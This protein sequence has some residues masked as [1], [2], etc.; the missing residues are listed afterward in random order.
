MGALFGR[1]EHPDVDAIH[2]R[3]VADHVSEEAAAQA[4]RLG[5]RFP[6]YGNTAAV[7]RLVHLAYTERES[8]IGRQL[9]DDEKLAARQEA[10]GREFTRTTGRAALDPVEMG[11][12]GRAPRREAVAGY[13]FTFTPVKSAAVLWGRGSE[14]TRQQIFEAHEAAV[15]DAL[16]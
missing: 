6:T 7:K 14:T 10:T 5:R 12:P 3:L 13:D 9:T 8:S 1:G 16:G 11:S 4:T 15:T 2:A